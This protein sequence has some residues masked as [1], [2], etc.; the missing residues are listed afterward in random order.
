MHADEIKL[1]LVVAGGK[2]DKAI[3]EQLRVAAGY[4]GEGLGKGSLA[5]VEVS[6]LPVHRRGDRVNAG[7]YA[8]VEAEFAV[9]R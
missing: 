9:R 6:A 4:G 1:R 2:V 3:I 7:A 8:L 5:G